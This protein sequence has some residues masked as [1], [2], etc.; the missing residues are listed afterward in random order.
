MILKQPKIMNSHS[1]L[2][3]S[4]SKHAQELYNEKLIWK[5]ISFIVVPHIEWN[6][7]K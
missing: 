4:V 1:Q 3:K 6:L 7:K 2:E 5:L